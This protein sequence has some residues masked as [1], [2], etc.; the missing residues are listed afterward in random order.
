MFFVVFYAIFLDGN[1]TPFLVFAAPLYEVT[2]WQS[3][4]KKA[5]IKYRLTYSILDSGNNVCDLTNVRNYI[6]NPPIPP[7]PQQSQCISIININLRNHILNLE[8]K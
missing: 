2:H 7:K 6:Y 5:L 8:L 4:K 3:L 1:W